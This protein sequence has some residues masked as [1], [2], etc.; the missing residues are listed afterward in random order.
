MIQRFVLV[1]ILAMLSGC[2]FQYGQHQA[3]HLTESYYSSLQVGDSRQDVWKLI[4]SPD[5]NLQAS[6]KDIYFVRIESYQDY[7]QSIEKDSANYLANQRLTLVYD[8]KGILQEKILE[9]IDLF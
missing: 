5:A 1:F 9:D 2:I 3:L 4:G 7:V 8:R 6:K